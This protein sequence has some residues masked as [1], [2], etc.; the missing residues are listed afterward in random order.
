M[1][2]SL[3]RETKDRLYEQFARLGHSVSSPKRL[4]LLDL[5]G[6]SEKTVETLAGQ[7]AMSVANTSRHL[8]ILRAARLV[9]TRKS[10]LYVLYRLADDEVGTFVRGLRRLAEKRMAEIDRL[11]AD[12]FNAPRLLQ[13]VDRRKLLRR[14]KSGEVIILD[15][16]PEDEYDTGH[17]PFA[18]SI[19]LSQLKVRL[20][21]LSPR[22]E[23]VAYC[24]GPY[25]VLAQEAV[26]FLRQR[27]FKALRLEDGVAEWSEAGLPVHLV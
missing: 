23:I 3:A 24:R 16:R 10:G 9:E 8:Q 11:I 2:T 13:P 17:L 26:S 7:S 1:K 27:G 5:L 19:P 15:V 14:A 12:Y 4:E 6:Q 20:K 18:V 25:C 22:K 21:E